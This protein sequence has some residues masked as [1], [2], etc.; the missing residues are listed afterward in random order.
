MV[1]ISLSGSGEGPGGAIPRGYSTSG[2][3]THGLWLSAGPKG[4]EGRSGGASG[5]VCRAHTGDRRRRIELL[6]YDSARGPVEVTGST[7]QRSENAPVAQEVVEGASG[8]ESR[9]GRGARVGGDAGA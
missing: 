4:A 5:V 8:G 3:G 9:R 1:E 7:P 6:R 2:P